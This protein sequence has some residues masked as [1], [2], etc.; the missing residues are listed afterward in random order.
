M[1][2]CLACK[3]IE[4]HPSTAQCRARHL[5]C[6]FAYLSGEPG[7]PAAP[8]PRTDGQK[9]RDVSGE[10]DPGATSRGQCAFLSWSCKETGCPGHNC[11]NR[12]M[13]RRSRSPATACTLVGVFGGVEGATQDLQLTSQQAWVQSDK[14]S[15]PAKATWFQRAPLVSWLCR[16][17][18]LAPL[19][20]GVIV[21][22]RLRQEPRDTGGGETVNTKLGRGF[23][24]TL[25]DGVCTSTLPDIYLAE[26]AA[27]A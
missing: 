26:S 10:A 2:R 9:R 22:R 6:P 24:T 20:A 7:S 5:V 21:H 27:A 19:I 25:L 13:L 12:N 18:P 3:V 17:R 14:G 4:G 1:S 16:F 15:R 11:A 23:V 8:K